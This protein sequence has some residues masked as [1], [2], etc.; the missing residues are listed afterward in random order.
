[1]NEQQEKRKTGTVLHPSGTTSETKYTPAQWIQQPKNQKQEEDEFNRLLSNSGDEIEMSTQP[2]DPAASEDPVLATDDEATATEETVPTTPHDAT[3]SALSSM[4][5]I[6]PEQFDEPGSD[7]VS[8]CNHLF[9]TPSFEKRHAECFPPF[10]VDDATSFHETDE[11]QD[12]EWIEAGNSPGVRSTVDDSSPFGDSP[13]PPTM[14]STFGIVEGD[15]RPRWNFPMGDS[16]ICTDTDACKSKDYSTLDPPSQN[17]SFDLEEPQSPTRTK[18]ESFE[19][20]CDDPILPPVTTAVVTESKH[21]TFR[22]MRTNISDGNSLESFGDDDDD[23]NFRDA[24]MLDPEHLACSGRFPTESPDPFCAQEESDDS[25]VGMVVGEGCSGDCPITS[26]PST[27][28]PQRRGDTALSQLELD[29]LAKKV[30]KASNEESQDIENPR[31]R[32]GPDRSTSVLSQ[33]ERDMLEKRSSRPDIFVDD[34]ENESL[35][36]KASNHRR[37]EFSGSGR[38]LRREE[39]EYF[40]K[41]QVIAHMEQRAAAVVPPVTSELQPPTTAEPT[42]ANE[43]DELQRI[44]PEPTVEEVPIRPLM[45]NTSLEEFRVDPPPI[46]AVD[47]PTFSEHG[48]ILKGPS[49]FD[50]EGGADGLVVARMVEEDEDWDRPSAFMVEPATKG[51]LKSFRVVNRLVALLVV[52]ML[53]IIGATVAVIL[54]TKKTLSPLPYRESIGLRESLARTVGLELLDDRNSPEFLALQWITH[55]DPLQLTPASPGLT[56]RFFLSAFYLATADRATGYGLG[57]DPS[58][59]VDDTT[60]NLEFRYLRDSPTMSRE[61]L[62]HRWLSGA[63]ECEW[64]GVECDG[65]GQVRKLQLRK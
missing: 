32:P 48:N 62:A 1:M 24:A 40:A 41:Q 51:P 2:H 43:E 19:R 63:P 53:L 13:P 4:H 39:E 5:F 37:A 17:V 59:E 27:V 34:H 11:L 61:V 23:D 6:S 56:Q 58:L 47:S 33:L 38:S 14:P 25:L 45:S 3:S 35:E 15:D 8:S 49:Y 64:A 52:L 18:L 57:C 22:R 29:I 65:L 60:C 12:S 44:L 10:Q 20:A 31:L 54:G 30:I 9:P 50:E 36:Q 7:G 42:P 55:E 21:E 16:D 46:T 26:E 28:L